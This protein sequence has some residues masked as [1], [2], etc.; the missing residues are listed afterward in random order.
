MP[1]C[2]LFVVIM[3]ISFGRGLFKKNPIYLFIFGC[4]G[5]SLLHMGFLWLRQSGYS[6][7]LACGLLNVMASLVAEHGL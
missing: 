2:L 3:R 6:L 7:V 4:T 1:T 5:S